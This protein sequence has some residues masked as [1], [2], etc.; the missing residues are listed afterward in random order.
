[1]G[2][3]LDTIFERRSDCPAD[4]ELD[5]HIEDC[6]LTENRRRDEVLTDD[7]Q[8]GIDIAD[9][10]GGGMDV[11]CDVPEASHAKV[12][13]AQDSTGVSAVTLSG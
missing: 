9:R 6:G 2:D 4:T 13:A 8:T 1:M 11:R 3:L 12:T 5:R 10:K 7:E